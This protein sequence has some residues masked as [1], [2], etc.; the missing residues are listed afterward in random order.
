MMRVHVYLLNGEDV[1]YLA[2][3]EIVENVFPLL[4]NTVSTITIRNK[5]YRITERNYELENQ[6]LNLYV[7]ECY[8]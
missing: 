4:L 3:Y 6:I 7:T 8:A 1:E 5:R 2:G